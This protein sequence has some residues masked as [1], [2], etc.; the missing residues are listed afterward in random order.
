MP[1]AGVAII[2]S[3]TPPQEAATFAYEIAR[4]LG[5]PIISGL[6]RGIDAAAHRG[7]LAAHVPTVAFVGYGFGCTSP[8]EHAELER[9][10]VEAGGAIA[11]L[12]PPG[13]P[14]SDKSLIARDRQQAEFARAI[15][16]ICSELDDGA[17][18]TMLFAKELGRPRFAVLPPPRFR[19]DAV[20]LGN[21]QC[22][23]D[24]AKPIPLDLAGA[25]KALG[26][27]STSSG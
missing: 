23:A 20:W 27:P 26:A 14:A 22:I 10:I 6:A 5:E 25:L 18:H 24:G 21:A 17:M 9:E 15:V 19:E 3:R 2:G 16:L 4:R 13:T 7:A 8:P 11:T 1:A 12:L